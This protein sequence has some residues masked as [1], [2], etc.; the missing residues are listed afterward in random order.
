MIE[1]AKR[2]AELLQHCG[3][4]TDGTGCLDC[5]YNLLDKENDP[6]CQSAVSQR[7]R[8]FAPAS[9]PV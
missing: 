3:S 9:R 6:L 2:T 8:N 7:C 4:H 5:P 1:E